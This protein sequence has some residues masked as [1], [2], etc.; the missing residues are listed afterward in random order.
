MENKNKMTTKK[1]AIKKITIPEEVQEVEKVQEPENFVLNFTS[2]LGKSVVTIPNDQIHHLAQA[3]HHF[4]LERNL[5]STFNH[6][7][8]P[9]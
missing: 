4:F 8:T 2:A 1:T 3:I 9:K 5:K 6:T 7:E